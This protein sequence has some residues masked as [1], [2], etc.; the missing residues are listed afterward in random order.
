VRRICRQVHRAILVLPILDW[1][2][3]SAQAPFTLPLSRYVTLINRVGQ[4]PIY[5]RCIY[6]IF[7][8]EITKYKLIYG[9]YIY[10][11][12]QPYI[13]RLSIL[14]TRASFDLHTRSLFDLPILQAPTHTHTHTHTL[15]HTHT[16]TH[17]HFLTCNSISCYAF[18]ELA[19]PT[20]TSLALDLPILDFQTDMQK[21]DS[22][23]ALAVK[24][25]LLM[26]YAGVHVHTHTHAYGH[27]HAHT[28]TPLPGYKSILPSPARGEQCRGSG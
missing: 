25:F 7:G 20:D 22:H 4:N 5:I 14:D 27:A 21:N 17:T 1:P 24:E 11:Y 26:V 16:H 28:H 9:A 6:G 12:G 15:T 3:L 13:F 8:K 10:N 2:I 23:L 18:R 19:N